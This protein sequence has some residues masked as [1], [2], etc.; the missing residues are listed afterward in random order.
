MRHAEF[1]VLARESGWIIVRDTGHRTGCLTI[2]NDPEWV[3]SMILRLDQ[4]SR[5]AY[6]DSEGDIVELEH[7]GW[8]FTGF[9]FPDPLIMRYVQRFGWRA[10]IDFFTRPRKG[11]EST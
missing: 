4:D 2:T 9:G 7:D 10:A 6:F 8:Y 1:E 5:I 3:V 11:Q